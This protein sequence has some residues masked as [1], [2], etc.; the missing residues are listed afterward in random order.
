M[1]KKIV[2]MA[3]ETKWWPYYI[4]KDLFEWL[5][6]AYWKEFDVYFYHTKKDWI[7]LHFQKFDYIFSVVPFLFK[8]LWAKNFI[9]NLRWNFEI[10]KKRKWLWNKLLYL[11]KW[12]LRFCDN[13]M[14]TSYFLADKLNFRKRYE[15]KIFILPNFIYIKE[16][17]FWERKFDNTNYK[18][19]TITSFK[20][21][22]KWKWILDL[23]TVISALW[24]KTDKKIF[25]TIVWND[26]WKN[27]EKIKKIF[28]NIPFWKNIEIYW[29]WWLDKQE[30]KNIL[31]NNDYFLYRTE[32]DNF[33]NI[34][35]EAI[36][37]KMKVL[38]NDFE[39]FQYFLDKKIICKNSEDMVKK[40][41]DDDIFIQ[42]IWYLNKYNVLY[43]LYLFMKKNG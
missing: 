1:K 30:I 10:E 31:R 19:L 2:F 7:R 36:W 15:N 34:L 5:K 35:L 42:D 27:F 28:D 8:P 3:P 13:I 23:W 24:K 37:S 39:S 18:V 33:P 22:K 41:V 29:K 11:S 26:D 40:I 43:S 6:N 38:V 17:N 9:Y 4:Y 14:L 21:Y 20:F 32:L 16:Y 25:W 12:N